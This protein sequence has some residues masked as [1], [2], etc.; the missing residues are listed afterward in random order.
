MSDETTYDASELLA[1][2]LPV[3]VERG[4]YAGK[5]RRYL[6]GDHDQLVEIA[7]HRRTTP[8]LLKI[9][10]LRD[11]LMPGVVRA[12][13]SRLH[14]TGWQTDFQDE[15]EAIAE[16]NRLPLLQKE[17]HQESPLGGDAGIVVWP[18]PDGKSRL[19]PVKAGSFAVT[20]DPVD[21]TKLTAAMRVWSEKRAGKP[22]VCA[23]IYTDAALY[24]L[25]TK[26]PCAKLPHKTS[27]WR[28][29]DVRDNPYG[30]NPFHHLPNDADLGTMGRSELD[31][32]LPLQDALNLALV[33]MKLGEE[34]VAWRQLVR[35]GAEVI[36]DPATGEVMPPR[37]G[38]G[39]VMDVGLGGDVKALPG[40]DLRPFLEEQDA[41]RREIA[42][43]TSTPLHMLSL[44]EGAPPSGDALDVLE[45]ALTDKVRDRQQEW[46]WPW[47][48]AM[49]MALYIDGVRVDGAEGAAGIEAIKV[50]PT[51][52]PPETTS[53]SKRVKLVEDKIAAGWP[54][55]L[56]FREAG[57]SDDEARQMVA[58]RAA[59]E[60]EASARRAI[61][62]D[63]GLVA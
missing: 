12:L 27:A 16:R 26:A 29:E 54:P 11:N 31:P 41:L 39:T 47:A 15:I 5:R 24:D 17:L 37:T 60:E 7:T 46:A 63:A 8:A 32:A 45:K 50:A 58:D 19:Y 1:D 40:A 13:T 28:I 43:V 51:W 53:E 35:I 21:L 52:A 9:V 48:A 61:D 34:D 3:V 56:A 22:Y 57:Y 33:N 59:F 14:V 55:V 10:Q 2:L 25:V 4:V 49:A 36:V 44:A 62:F 23:T 20:Y 30:L 42:A 38:P 18:G 6:D